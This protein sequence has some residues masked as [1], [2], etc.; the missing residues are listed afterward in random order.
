M[1]LLSNESMMARLM[2]NTGDLQFNMALGSWMKPGIS[3]I[4]PVHF[5]D[6]CSV[7]HV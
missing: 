5:I 3:H 1:K 4:Y 6:E 7:W 2:A